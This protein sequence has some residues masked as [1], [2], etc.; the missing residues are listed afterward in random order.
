MDFKPTFQFSWQNP[1]LRDDIYPFRMEK[2]RDFLLVYR[3]VD[4]WK[5]RKDAPVDTDAAGK[6]KEAY[7]R[8]G[9]ELLAATEERNAADS[10]LRTLKDENRQLL[11]SREVRLLERQKT[12]LE[13]QISELDAKMG[14]FKRQTEWYQKF[15]PEHP[16]LLKWQKEY[17]KLVPS[18]EEFTQ[19]LAEVQV[20][21][22]AIL[23]PFIESAK[24]LEKRITE[25]SKSIQST[26]LEMNKLPNL[27]ASGEVTQKALVR[28]ELMN[29]ERELKA[30][31]HD[32][33]VKRVIDFFDESGDRFPDWLRYMVIHFSGMRY[34][35]AH[36]SWADPR[37]LIEMIR[38]EEVK[39]EHAQESDEKIE[40]L[41]GDALKELDREK[42]HT[43]DVDRRKWIDRHLLRLSSTS[44]A[45]AKAN[46]L[47]YQID[48]AVEEIASWSDAAVLGQLKSRK[49][50]FPDWVW[51]EIQQRTQ[52]KLDI[53]VDDWEGLTPEQRQERWTKENSRW[54]E[55]MNVWVTKDITEWR[56]KHRATLE[57]IV[58]RAVCNEICEH[59]QHLRGI[60][61]ASGLTAKPTWYL[62][63]QRRSQDDS[64]FLLPT[65]SANLVQGASLLF[66][67]WVE[68]KPNPW[69]IARSL[70]PEVELLPDEAKPD[71][72]RSRQLKKNEDKGKARRTQEWRYRLQSNEFIRQVRPWVKTFVEMPDNK[73]KKLRKEGK[74]EFEIRAMRKERWVRGQMVT[75]WLRWTHE[76][77]VV[78]V[79]EMVDG[80][81]VVTF[82]TG[83]IGINLRSLWRVLNHWDVYVG[84]T[85]PADK[86]PKALTEMLDRKRL[87]LNAGS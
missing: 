23:A 86:P 9:E 82:E 14:T 73:I 26:T 25:A 30:L 20:K 84:Y 7:R 60:K 16:Y 83:K 43:Q 6:L 66:L 22:D 11:R 17:E 50:T 1:N 72:S 41:I 71:K 44:F 62:N 52:L 18:R 75:E 77:T 42:R 80:W 3:E 87:L 65:D 31:D 78:E 55:L 53:Q 36:A 33:L 56:A 54:R 35:S 45:V 70:A 51:A 61:P 2:L 63:L 81:Q 68:R 47:R 69:Q 85:P 39:A 38:I 58:T 24:V 46:L 28:Y 79:V 59:I 76:A 40:I 67:G 13:R 4:L 12:I 64:F 8:L 49:E 5:Q 37:E 48:R 15:A 19:A 57:L 21:L 29:Y 34:R 10:Q 27:E 74:T 32:T